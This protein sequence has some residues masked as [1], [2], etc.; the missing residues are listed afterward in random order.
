MSPL[1]IEEVYE[2]LCYYDKRNPNNDINTDFPKEP[3]G[4]CYCD[5]CFHGRDRLA[6]E[7]IALRELL[8]I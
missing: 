5:N 4:N 1:E 7:I 2:R 6:L 3:R 8:K